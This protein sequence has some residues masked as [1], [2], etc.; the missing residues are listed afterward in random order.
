M[1]TIVALSSGRA[2]AA[3]GVIRISGPAALSAATALAG[4]LPD[5]R[6]AALRALRTPSGEL[7]DRALVIAFPGP[8]SVTGEDL[9]ELHCHGGRS[10]LAG[11]TAALCSMPEV[12]EAEPGE[13]TRRALANGQID[14]AQAEGLADLLEAETDAQRRAALMASEGRVSATV[15]A[16][17]DRL[18][19][20][21][22]QIEASLDYAEE[23]DVGSETALLEQTR[24][25]AAT[26]ADEMRAVL[27]AP[28]VER[29]RDGIRVVIAG[30]PNT[31]KST[32]LN[33]M[34]ERDAAIVS[35]QAGTTRD[36]IEVPVVREG[37]AY[38]LTD[39]A[40]LNDA[41]D[42]IEAMGVTRAEAAVAAADLVIWSGDMPPPRA[43]AMWVHTRS[44]LAERARLPTGRLIATRHD[45]PSTIDT[46]WKEVAGRACS[47]LP[48]S[49]VL[50][51]SATQR[52]ACARAV[53][54]LQ[55]ANDP[56]IAAEQLRRATWELATILGVNATEAMLDAL[57]GRFCLGK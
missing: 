37:I 9:V 35:A 34:C 46:L 18:A 47:L 17:L 52:K 36:R 50:P 48:G 57:F 6:F 56:L 54:E 55:L 19:L 27:A 8:A 10:V 13:F 40:G 15:R 31:G 25:A 32:L 26:L 42:P 39:T 16:W 24:A 23:G 30:P 4:T 53:N 43:D 5:P 20:M 33:L 1:D 49:D 12:R 45:V 14:F 38:V 44:D 51:V 3:I 11:V 28:P 29:L 41:S 22:A 21:S 2:P 7:L